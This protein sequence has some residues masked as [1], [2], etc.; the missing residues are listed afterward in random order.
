ML[1]LFD[2]NVRPDA[3]DV[4]PWAMRSPYLS[5]STQ[6]ARPKSRIHQIL[7]MPHTWAYS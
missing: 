5:P 1:I 2:P 6:L 4:D 3:P 7:P